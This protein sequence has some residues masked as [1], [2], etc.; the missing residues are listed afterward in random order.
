VAK[1]RSVR[2]TESQHKDS[3][4]SSS[5]GAGTQAERLKEIKERYASTRAVG[6]RT[7]ETPP[8]RR[9]LRR[10][11]RGVF[12]EM[13]TYLWAP[14]DMYEGGKKARQSRW[15]VCGP[16]TEVRLGAIKHTGRKGEGSTTQ[17]QLRKE[18]KRRETTR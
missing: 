7:W 1:A 10:A 2:K 12:P 17:Q 8:A 3:G 14:A 5:D 16:G 9:L 11:R 6:E 4:E 15:E 13:G 18:V